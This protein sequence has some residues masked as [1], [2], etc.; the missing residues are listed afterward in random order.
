MTARNSPVEDERA[1]LSLCAHGTRAAADALSRLIDAAESVVEGPERVT[2]AELERRVGPDVTAIGF[3][4]SGGFE[5]ALLHVLTP[6][7]AD[8]LLARLPGRVRPHAALERAQGALAELGNIAASAFLNAVATEVRRACLPS[9]PRFGGGG[10][11]GALE[12][13]DVDPEHRGLVLVCAR[14]TIEGAPPVR[15]SLVVA[16]EPVTIAALRELAATA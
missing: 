14:V 7:D 10:L 13:V 3:R 12:H 5:G 2:V 15:L 16:P 8:A 11:R 4:L 6:D 1:L 9:V